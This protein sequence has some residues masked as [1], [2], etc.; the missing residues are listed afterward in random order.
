MASRKIAAVHQPDKFTVDQMMKRVGVESK[1]R[2]WLWAG[3]FYL[4]GY[5]RLNLRGKTYYAHRLMFAHIHG[6]APEGIQ[7]CHHCDN[8]TCVNPSHLF[9]GTRSD[10]AKDMMAKGRGRGQFSTDSTSGE[11]N[12]KAKLSRQQVDEMRSLFRGGGFS[13]KELGRRFG[14]TSVMACYIIN[15]KHWK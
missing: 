1:D 12:V 5:G 10:N 11:R 6:L 13:K 3:P 15:G 2:C 7:I 9:A 8:P 14:I 4:R